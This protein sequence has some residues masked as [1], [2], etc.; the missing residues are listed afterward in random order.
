[1][2]K[3]KQFF[4]L[5]SGAHNELLKKCPTESSKYVGIGATVFFTGIFAAIACAYALYTVFDNVWTSIAF[6][7]VWGL[8]IFNLD[9]YIV[10]SMR[11]EGNVKKELLTAFP[12]IILAV[13]ISLIIAKPLEMKIF[14]KEI[15]GELTIMEQQ[16]RTA[17]ESEIRMRYQQEQERLNNEIAVLKKEIADKTIKRDE[18]MKL[19]QEEADGTGGTKKR[20][21]GPIYKIKKADADRVDHELAELTKQNESLIREKVTALSTNDSLVAAEINALEKQRLDGPAAR[22]EALS[23]LTEKSAAIAL[24][25]WFIILLFIAV[26][27]APVFV[28]LI[29]PQGPYDHLL[30]IEEHGFEGQRIEE[31]AKTNAA[32]KE[33]NEKLSQTEKEYIKDKLDLKLNGS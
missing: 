15:Q 2:E 5:C 3:L 11:K 24:A 31:L 1:M 22:M 32:I 17:Q 25:N 18:L 7:I 6:G 14:S 33:R 26:E 21:A 12:R 9:R 28:K 8:M 13:L 16:T 10:S 27:T 30:K 4:W 29:S 20:N 23:R 19:A